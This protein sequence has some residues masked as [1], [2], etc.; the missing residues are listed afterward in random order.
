MLN[1][2]QV[3]YFH[4]IRLFFSINIFYSLESLTDLPRL[5]VHHNDP[6]QYYP[7]VLNYIGLNS[8]SLYRCPDGSTFDEV[9]Q[10]C[11]VKIPINDAFEQFASLPSIQDAPFHHIASFVL[12]TTTPND[13]NDYQE[14]NVISLTPTIEKLIQPFSLKDILRH[15]NIY[16][17]NRDN[18][19]FVFVQRMKRNL[20][21]GPSGGGVIWSHGHPLM[22]LN[23]QPIALDPPTISPR[24]SHFSVVVRQ[25]VAINEG[26]LIKKKNFRFFYELF[27]LF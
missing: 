15:V 25:P 14:N 26:Y 20:P 7:C 1:N 5:C 4:R 16:I 27:N 6:S 13:E 17:N 23:N 3:K 11:L 18:I 19:L 24:L 12:D 8:W 22:R 21:D 2:F 10:E 9:S